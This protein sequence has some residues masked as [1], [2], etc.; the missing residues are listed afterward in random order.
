MG[1]SFTKSI[2]ISFLV[3][4]PL[5]N[6]SLFQLRVYYST[7]QHTFLSQKTP[8]HFSFQSGGG[9]GVTGIFVNME[10]NLHKFNIVLVHFYRFAPLARQFTPFEVRLT[11]PPV[12]LFPAT[13]S[14]MCPQH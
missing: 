10:I 14:T 3:F 2:L 12:K 1:I 5:R 4:I 9:M 7:V 8:K 11:S 13:T 6:F